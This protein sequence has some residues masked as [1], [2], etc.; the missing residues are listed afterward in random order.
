MS[1]PRGG[2]SAERAGAGA[3]ETAA[4]AARARRKLLRGI[5]ADTEPRLTREAD[6]G[7]VARGGKYKINVSKETFY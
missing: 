1:D 5:G 7:R 2:G 6:L 4:G 3:S